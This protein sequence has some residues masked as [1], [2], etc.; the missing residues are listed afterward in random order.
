MTD[1]ERI[2]NVVLCM[3][4]VFR[5]A[6]DYVRREEP[7]PGDLV[8]AQTSRISPWKVCWMVKPAEDSNSPALVRE[9]GGP[10][11]CNYSNE[12]FVTIPVQGTIYQDEVNEGDEYQLIKKV[13]KAVTKIEKYPHKIEGFYFEGDRAWDVK[14]PCSVKFRAH[15]FAN[16]KGTYTIPLGKY[17][18]KT[19]IKD[20]TK[21]LLEGGFGDDSLLKE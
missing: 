21:V 15:I 8:L 5:S 18:S 12:S 10:K 9:V 3:L 13:R 6:S 7:K 2:H 14:R 1:K 17:S 20:L 11:L 4:P 19:S 16:W